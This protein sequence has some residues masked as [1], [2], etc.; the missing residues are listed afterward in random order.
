MDL[1]EKATEAEE[2]LIKELADCALNQRPVSSL[3]AEMLKALAAYRQAWAVVA[4]AR[5]T[6]QLASSV[7]NVS[8]ELFKIDVAISHLKD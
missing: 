1:E 8:T 4:L 5:A 2:K 6:E 7:D 3:Q